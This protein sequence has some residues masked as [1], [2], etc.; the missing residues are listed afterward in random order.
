MLPPHGVWVTEAKNAT[1]QYAPCL[2]A[3]L[4]FA[5]AIVNIGD[6]LL[7]CINNSKCNTEWCYLYL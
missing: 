3:L 1:D 7:C 6:V 5:R 4:L 2:Q